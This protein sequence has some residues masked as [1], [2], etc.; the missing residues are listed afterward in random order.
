MTRQPKYRPE[1]LAELIKETLA[2][3]FL[4]ELK[5]PRVGFITITG[6]KVTADGSHATVSV[7]VMGS[8][9]EKTR[10]ME[11]LNNARGFL[12]TYLAQ[13]LSLRVAPELHFRLDRTLEHARRI[14][15]L[16]AEIRRGKSG[17]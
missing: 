11:G 14:D 17:S 5:D 15:E 8:E 1:R 6:V 7:S 2:D 3:A 13:H 12:R 4:T 9:E 10:S 16:L